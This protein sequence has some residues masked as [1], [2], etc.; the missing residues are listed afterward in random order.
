MKF[1]VRKV[2]LSNIPIKKEGNHAKWNHRLLLFGIVQP[3]LLLPLNL[4]GSGSQ[5]S[6]DNHFLLVYID[7]IKNAIQQLF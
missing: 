2:D 6:G 5:V 3:N 4:K 1:V 7:T